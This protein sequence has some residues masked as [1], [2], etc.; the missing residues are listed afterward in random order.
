MDSISE[1]EGRVGVEEEEEVVEEEEEEEEGILSWWWYRSCGRFR[2]D[3]REW[4]GE[5]TK[6]RAQ[7]PKRKGSER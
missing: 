7:G 5:R 3:G 1:A 2:T 4:R 6:E